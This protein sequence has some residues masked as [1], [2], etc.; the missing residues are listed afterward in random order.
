MYK[1]QSGKA[2]DFIVCYPFLAKILPKRDKWEV[3]GERNRINLKKLWHFLIS[4]Y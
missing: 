3:Q 2:T 1:K 4:F